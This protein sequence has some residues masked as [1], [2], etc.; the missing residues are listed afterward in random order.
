MN[1]RGSFYFI[2]W[3][4]N[5]K[6]NNNQYYAAK[7]FENCSKRQFYSMRNKEQYVHTLSCSRRS[8]IG[9][10]ANLLDVHYPG[11]SLLKAASRLNL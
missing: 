8:W 10:L 1:A 3:L 6:D 5:L 11:P 9:L 2:L 4:I 7:P